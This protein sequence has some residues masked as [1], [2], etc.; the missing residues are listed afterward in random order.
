M[1]F[2]RAPLRIA[3]QKVVLTVEE[4]VLSAL[5]N[6]RDLRVERLTPQITATFEDIER[7]VYDPE[8]FAGV[9]VSEDEAVEVSRATEENFS[10]IRNDSSLDAGVRQQFPSGT[11]L[12]L[13]ASTARST[14]NRSPEQRDVRIGLT[15]TQAL[16]RGANTTVNLARIQQAELETVASL[17]Q[18]QGFTEALLAEAESVYWQFALASQRIRIFEESLELARRQQ[19][20]VEQRIEIGVIGRTE[21]AAVRAEVAQREQDLIDARSEREI[22]RLRL[23][24]LIN[25]DV[26]TSESENDDAVFLLDVVAET[27]P[28]TTMDALPDL[29]DR[30][31]LALKRRPDLNEAR[32]RLDQARLETILTRDGLLPRLDFF[33]TFGKTGYAE[34]VSNAVRELD[35]RTFDLTAGLELSYPIGNRQAEGF[36]R[37]SILARRQAAEA[38]S[39]LEQLIRLD[40]RIAAAEVERSRQQITATAATRTLREEALRVE[41]ERFNVGEST[42]LL[43]AQAQRDLVESQINEVEALIGYRLALIDLYLAEGALLARRGLTLDEADQL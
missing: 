22:L 29:A 1:P 16:L 11:A 31:Q 8:F 10:V 23:L 38:I 19:A 43:I 39:N 40:V 25:P 14:S 34:A 36:D 18:L 30:I 9:T 6:N 33:V 4:V 32:L 24:R 21:A 41:T 28:A 20:E 12:E 42:G 17:Y 2:A 7:G 35:G 5:Q 13:G 15:L 26:E 3:D 37:Q 27:D